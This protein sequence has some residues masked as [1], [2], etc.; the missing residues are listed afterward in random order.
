MRDVFEAATAEGVSNRADCVSTLQID[1]AEV[2]LIFIKVIAVLDQIVG[3]IAE[4]NGLV[5]A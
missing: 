5:I 2:C 4:V 3:A 1:N